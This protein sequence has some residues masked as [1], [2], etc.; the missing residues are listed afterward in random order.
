[1][2]ICA[3][4]A[5]ILAFST[6]LSGI[7]SPFTGDWFDV[8]TATYCIAISIWMIVFEIYLKGRD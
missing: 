3:T 1:M 6:F 7:I 8:E 2:N 4:L 5:V